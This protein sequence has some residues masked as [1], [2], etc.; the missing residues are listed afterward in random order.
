[1]TKENIEDEV[2]AFEEKITQNPFASDGLV[3][4]FDSLK[5]SA[6]LGATSKFPKDSMAF[7]WADEMSETKLLSIEWNPSRTGLINPVAVFEPVDIEGS[8]VEKASVHNVSIMQE[9]ALGEGDIIKVYKANMIIPQ[10]AENLTGSGTA[11]I[12]ESCPACGAPT[13]IVGLK[14]GKALYCT[15]PVCKAKLIMGLTHYVSRDAMNIDGL[16]QQTIEKFV[17][18]GFLADYTDLYSLQRFE[19]E[20]VAMEGFGRKSYDNLIESINKSRSCFLANFIYALGINQVGLSNAKLLCGYYDNDIEKIIAAL[21]EELAEIEGFGGVISQSLASWFSHADNIARLRKT[22]PELSISIPESSAKSSLKGL[23]FA[24]TGDVS[25]FASR[26]A[27]QAKIESLGGKAA[28]SVTSKTSFL[29]NNDSLSESSKNKKAKQ[30]GIPI[31]TEQELAS[32]F[33]ELL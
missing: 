4:T 20:I 24:V 2:R 22:I 28:S 1:V 15:N 32:R 8:T 23:S 9:L 17:E 14:E 33:P 27:L 5:Y 26:K 13:E 29:V 6:S 25:M 18:R 10:I 16:S 21:P 12:P 3:L 19:D 30:L 7:K 11:Q 31:L